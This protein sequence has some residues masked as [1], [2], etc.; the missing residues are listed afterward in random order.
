VNFPR[1]AMRECRVSR[2]RWKGIFHASAAIALIQIAPAVHAQLINPDRPGVGSSAET[3]PQFT[4]EAELGTD[5]KEI[6]LGVLHGFELDRDDTSWGAK[7]G[8]VDN[9][10]LQMALKLSY[11]NDRK[12]VIEVPANYSFN[13]WF[14]LGADVIWS[15]SS[16]SYASEFIFTP[17]TRVTITPILYYDTKARGAIFAAW[18][19]PRHDNVQFDIGYD[20]H[21]VSLGISTAFN[22]ARVL[23]HR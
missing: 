16:Q 13:A 8:L 22:L 21:E 20:K 3:V 7:L 4:V 23:K 18:I 10:K 19:P 12:T 5:G 11:D 2:R 14:H 1:A 9:A 6:R 15:N 17:T